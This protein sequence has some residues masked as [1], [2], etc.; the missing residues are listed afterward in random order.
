METVL[1]VKFRQVPRLDTSHLVRFWEQRLAGELP[2]IEERPRY[3]PPL[4]RLES[5]GRQATFTLSLD[6]STTSPRFLCFSD[7]DLVQLQHDWFAY[8][9]RKTS[10]YPEYGSYE[11]GRDKFKK[12][13]AEFADFVDTQLG[14]P[15]APVQYEM[16]YVNHIEL[17]PEDLT[18]GP[19]GGVLRSIVPKSGK[20]LPMPT[21]AKHAMTYEITD[22]STSGRVSLRGRMH[23][24]AEHAWSEDMSDSFLLL[25]LTARGAA[26]PSAGGDLSCFFDLAHVWIVNGFVDVT[27]KALHERWGLVHR[28]GE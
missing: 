8:N 12:W 27:S 22:S 25:N 26:D 11:T 16:T 3:E 24:T 17:T 10:N 9:W 7:N 15:L 4:E 2:N 6:T 14:L 23:V 13:Y 21:S 18:A 5:N 28:E 19:F 20:F 1:A